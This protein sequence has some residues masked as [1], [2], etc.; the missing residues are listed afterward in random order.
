MRDPLESLAAE[1]RQGGGLLA[2]EVADVPDYSHTTWSAV[3]AE[4]PRTAAEA[5]TYA[6]V[7]EAIWEGYLLHYGTPR[8]LRCQD[9]DLRLL[10]GD[11]LFA[12]GLARLVE[13]E[14]LTAVAELADM[15]GL[16]ALAHARGQA[17]LVEA[18]WT[19]GVRAIGWGPT[20]EHA[21]AKRLAREGDPAAQRALRS[22]G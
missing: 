13:L 19:A 16:S 20:G 10:A 1:L 3:V 7:I 6:L 4:A 11:R 9:A 21:E 18:V 17:E 15:I 12:L 5:S 14:D 8:M 2:A 22:V